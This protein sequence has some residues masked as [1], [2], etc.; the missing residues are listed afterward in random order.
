MSSQLSTE[1]RRLHARNDYE[2]H[3]LLSMIERMHR[4]GRSEHEIVAALDEAGA[5]SPRSRRSR[6]NT[7]P[8]RGRLARWA[9]R[10][11]RA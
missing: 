9:A 2:Q 5:K 4:E 11:G 6:S 10:R 7:R 3:R 1:V 8:V